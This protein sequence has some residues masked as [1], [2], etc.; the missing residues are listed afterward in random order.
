MRKQLLK[1][2]LLTFSL[3]FLVS[4]TNNPLQVDV[5]EV[6]PVQ[7]S[8]SRMERDVFEAPHDSLEGNML[9]RKY[10]NFYE[11]FVRN[12]INTGIMPDSILVSSTPDFHF[13][14]KSAIPNDA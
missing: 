10:G 13:I 5:S 8:I 1:T 9:R 7:V 2:K 11:R 4:C 14:F 3:L 12:V 6:P